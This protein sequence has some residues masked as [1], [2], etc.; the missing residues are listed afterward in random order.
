MNLRFIQKLT[1]FSLVALFITSIL[2]LSIVPTTFAACSTSH[3]TP[4]FGQVTSSATVA[5]GTY[6]VWSRIKAASATNN[7]YDLQLVDNCTYAKTI[8][9]TTVGSWVWV[10]A[11][12]NF[13][14]T[15]STVA[16]TMFGTED[17]VMLDRVIL[18]A[19]TSC[20]PTGTGDN[21]AA[22]TYTKPGDANDDTRINAIDLS[23]LISHDNQN[24]AAADFNHDGT[25]GAADLAILLANWTW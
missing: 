14:T 24:Y 13:T 10:A 4:P 15:S 2:C 25:V 18:A 19:D 21:C 22:S 5:A 1:S 17:G 12:T 3:A 11:D 23:I 20:V 8:S 7:A 6:K 16:I 9:T